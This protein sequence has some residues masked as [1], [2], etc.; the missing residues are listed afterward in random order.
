FTIER[1]LHNVVLGGMLWLTTYSWWGGYTVYVSFI[2]CST[3]SSNYAIVLFTLLAFSWITYS[4]NTMFILG[5]AVCETAK[6]GTFKRILNGS[7]LLNL[8]AQVVLACVAFCIMWVGPI[9]DGL[10]KGFNHLAIPHARSQVDTTRLFITK[11]IVATLLLIWAEMSPQARWV[12]SARPM[13]WFARLSS[14]VCLLSIAA[15]YLILPRVAAN[16]AG[17]TISV[18]MVWGAYFATLAATC[19]AAAVFHF[20]VE[21]PS[22]IMGRAAWWLVGGEDK[23][24]FA[25]R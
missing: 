15:V 9:E 22:V 24:T 7:T 10:N 25:W 18:A 12:L 5:Y 3:L 16:A 2:V 6:R 13:R 17:P 8:G 1:P 21:W 23:L 11:I 19:L 20:A 14:G 4:Y